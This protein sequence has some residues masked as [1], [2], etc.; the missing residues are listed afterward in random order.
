MGYFQKQ[1]PKLL[2]EKRC[3]WKFHKIY[4]KTPVP[5]SGSGT[6]FFLW[7]LWNFQEHLLTEHIRVTASIFSSSMIHL[8][9]KVIFGII[10]EV[11]NDTWR[12]IVTLYFKKAIT[13]SSFMLKRKC[14]LIDITTK[15]LRR[16]YLLKFTGH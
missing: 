15:Y 4:R 2:Y 8:L 16:K 3:S 7:I 14:E 1:P 13:N 10:T 6:G 11:L 5:E 9:K 12:P